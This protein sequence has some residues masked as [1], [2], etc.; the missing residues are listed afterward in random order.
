MATQLFHTSSTDV[1]WLFIGS[2]TRTAVE[3]N[4]G[5]VSGIFPLQP[6]WRV[7]SCVARLPPRVPQEPFSY[8]FPS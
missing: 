7:T 6:F 5:I 3:V 2:S 4:I 1:T 8:R